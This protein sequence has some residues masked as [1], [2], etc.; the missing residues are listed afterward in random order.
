[1][2]K[3]NFILGVVLKI[4]IIFITANVSAQQKYSD[5]FLDSAKLL[6]KSTKGI[7]MEEYINFDYNHIVSLLQRSI[8]LNSQNP[9]A[10]YFMGYAYSRTNAKDGRGMIGMN[11]DLVIKSSE[12]FEKVIKLTPKYNGEFISLDPY[13]KLSSEWGS[14]GLSYMYKNNYDSSLWAFKEGKKRGGFGDFILELNKEILNNCEKNAILL[15]DGDNFTIPLWYLQQVEKYRPDVSIVDLSLLNTNWYPTYLARTHAVNFDLPIEKLDTINYKYWKEKTITI[16]QFSWILKPS[17]YN[18]YLSR[19]DRVLLSILRENKFRRNIYFT[20]AGRDE[21]KLSL[22]KYL[23]P[24]VFNEKL[25]IVKGLSFSHEKY[26]YAINKALQLSNKLNINSQEEC[27][28]FDY[29]R[30]DLLI[31]AEDYLMKGEKI[32]AKEI[33]SILDKNV[34]VNEFPYQITK[35][36]EFENHIRKKINQ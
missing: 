11:K 24:Q 31:R 28:L 35:G 21:Y 4:Q 26:M 6:F 15:T 18:S 34:N 32:R 10:H 29:F 23:I 12:E 13:S 3:Y 27:R 8:E 30:Y 1:M 2:K 25:S 9:E 33:I 19:G 20:F 5:V 17:I 36:L 14:L 22:N 7:S 16:E